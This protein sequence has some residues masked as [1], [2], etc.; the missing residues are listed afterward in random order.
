MVAVVPVP[1]VITPPGLRVKV[2]VPVAGKPLKSTLPVA[3]V[4]VGCT[5]VLTVGAG[6]GGGSV[7]VTGGAVAVQV[8][9]AAT[10]AVTVYGE[11]AALTIKV[12]PGW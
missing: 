9:V 1:V 10:L 8:G 11:P 2:H 3:T 6:T 12:F 5:I 7:T 4:H